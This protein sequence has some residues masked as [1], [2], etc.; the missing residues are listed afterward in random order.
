MSNK[1]NLNLTFTWVVPVME[2]TN[3]G[4]LEHV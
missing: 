4:M 1:N 3:D 2:V